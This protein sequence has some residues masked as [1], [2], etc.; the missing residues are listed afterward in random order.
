[1]YSS[2]QRRSKSLYRKSKKTGV[3]K[4]LKAPKRKKVKKIKRTRNHGTLPSR[5]SFRHRPTNDIYS[6]TS[7]PTEIHYETEDEYEPGNPFFSPRLSNDES[8]VSISFDEMEERVR[9][10][11]WKLDKLM[12]ENDQERNDHSV[13]TDQCVICMDSNPTTGFIPCGHKVSCY[14]CARIVKHSPSSKCPICRA[15]IKDVLRIYD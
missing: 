2:R 4:V 7:A 10:L 14:D 15:D 5:Y 9:E 11:T 13:K 6:V 3:R 12:M 8:S 1:M